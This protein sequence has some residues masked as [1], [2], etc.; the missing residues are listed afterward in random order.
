MQVELVNAYKGAIVKS[1]GVER[2]YCVSVVKLNASEP[3]KTCRKREDDVKTVGGDVLA[4]AR[5]NK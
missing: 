1:Y 2:L 4:G 5:C 3:L